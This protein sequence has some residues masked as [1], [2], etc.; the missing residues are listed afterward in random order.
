M[1]NPALLFTNIRQLLTLRGPAPRRG[2]QLL[3][4]GILEDAAVL[5]AG[6]KIV[7][8]GTR[9]E[10]RRDGWLKEHGNRGAHLREIDCG[11]GV[12]L[13]GFV[14]AHTHPAF[15]APRLPDFEKRIS[16]ATYQQIARAGGGIQ[17]SV[18]AVRQISPGGL[19]SAVRSALQ[20]MAA[21]GTTTVEAKSGYGLNL[22]AE[23]KSLEAIRNAARQWPGTVAPTLLGAHVIPREYASR[24]QRYVDLVCNQMI[25][26]VSRRKL[27]QFVDIFIERQAFWSRRSA[28]QPREFI[29]AWDC[30]PM[31][32]NS[33]APRSVPCWRS[34]PR[35]ST[36]STTSAMPTSAPWRAAAP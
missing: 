20:Q 30:G 33:A 14:D 24:P 19:A 22:Q 5:C 17:S 31:S 9:A 13:P 12:L 34:N 1:P 8:L 21:H 15:A 6:G 11:G 3:E 23:I 2:P 18:E 32:H 25:P 4:L 7:C 26:A 29:T 28:S 36:I 16:G 10:A 35:R 27:A